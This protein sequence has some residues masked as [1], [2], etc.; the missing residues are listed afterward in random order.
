MAWNEEKGLSISFIYDPATM[1]NLKAPN[2][3]PES[4]FDTHFLLLE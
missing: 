2:N 1:F 3:I 4:N